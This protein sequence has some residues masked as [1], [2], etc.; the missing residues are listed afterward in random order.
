[1][2][3]SLNSRLESNKQEEAETHTSLC[4]GGFVRNVRAAGVHAWRPCARMAAVSVVR[5]RADSA[6]MRQSRLDSGRDC[7]VKAL[8]TECRYA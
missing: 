1:M 3:V 2:V 7:Q 5:C 4:G 6:H 8:T